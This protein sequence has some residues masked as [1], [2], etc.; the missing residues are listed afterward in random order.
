MNKK[1]ILVKVEAYRCDY[2]MH[3]VELDGIIGINPIEDMFD[4]LLSYPIC[5]PDKTNVHAC[6]ECYKKVVLIPAGNLVNRK[7]SETAYKAKIK[8]LGYGF[9]SQA[10]RNYWEA[11]RKD[12]KKRMS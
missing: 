11:I 6:G 9:R 10:V 4:K 12:S 2:G 7:K 1:Y 8:E 3:I 5:K